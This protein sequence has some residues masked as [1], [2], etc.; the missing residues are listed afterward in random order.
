M[1]CRLAMKSDAKEAADY[2]H[3]AIH[4][5]AEALTG[6]KETEKIREVL[7]ELFRQENNR[8]SYQNSIV[9][10]IDGKV[11]GILIAYSGDDAVELDKPILERLKRIGKS[12]V[13][14]FDNEADKGD[15]YID[16]VSVVP[17]FQGRGIGTFLIQSVEQ[18]AK[19]KGFTRV[20]L[21]VAED[22]PGA[23]RLYEKLGY[24]KEKNIMINGHEF[25]YMVKSV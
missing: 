5:I 9:A 17:D 22:N 18:V 4:D 19:D 15:Y 6:E 20:S 3:L 1:E 25:D 12:H 2:I 7:S 10:E 24:M 23:K 11:A 13:E 14:P 16:T 8:L 21:N